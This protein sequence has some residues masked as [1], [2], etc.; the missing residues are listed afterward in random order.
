[1]II[2]FN[3]L[4]KTCNRI[5]FAQGEKNK[6]NMKDA[7]ELVFPQSVEFVCKSQLHQQGQSWRKS[8]GDISKLV[9]FV[10]Q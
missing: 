4:L 2:E 7:F 1:M 6:F 9:D 10:S 8:I 5:K 3:L